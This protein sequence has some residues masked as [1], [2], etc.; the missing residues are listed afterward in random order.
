MPPAI[1]SIPSVPAITGTVTAHAA[2]REMDFFPQSADIF[3]L[4][5]ISGSGNEYGIQVQTSGAAGASYVKL[6]QIEGVTVT[7]W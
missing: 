7:G 4:A 6:K 1:W 3:D 2:N 5:T